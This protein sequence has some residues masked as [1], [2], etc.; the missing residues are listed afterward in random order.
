MEIG[1]LLREFAFADL[2]SVV[3]PEIPMVLR[4]QQNETTLI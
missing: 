3:Y 1:C 2:F 4:D